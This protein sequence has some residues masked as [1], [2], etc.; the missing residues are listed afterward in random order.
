LILELTTSHFSSEVADTVLFAPTAN[1][2]IRAVELQ[3]RNMGDVKASNLLSSDT[4]HG[5]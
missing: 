2:I 1:P 4:F 5:C 3:L